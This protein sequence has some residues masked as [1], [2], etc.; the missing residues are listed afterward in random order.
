VAASPR[1][2]HVVL[3]RAG[4]EA[5]IYWSD[6][7]AAAFRE[8]HR[9]RDISAV[10]LDASEQLWVATAR[11]LWR[12]ADRGHSF[13]RV[14]AESWSCLAERAGHI[15]GCREPGAATLVA[16][17]ARDSALSGLLAPRRDLRG[18]LVCGGRAAVAT[19][20]A[21]RWPGLAALLGIS[22]P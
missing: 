17:S 3:A 7:A 4:R 14:A 6:S 2:T 5:A 20:C 18:P 11:G 16:V 19:L 21:P 9:A 15:Y 1:G 22:A 10:L 13:A 8:C 12:S